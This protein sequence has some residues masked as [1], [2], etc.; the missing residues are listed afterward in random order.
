MRNNQLTLENMLADPIARLTVDRDGVAEAD[1]RNPIED[2]R[3]R[4]SA[5]AEAGALEPA[6]CCAA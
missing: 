1:V 3:R 4:R 5:L 6:L 2:E